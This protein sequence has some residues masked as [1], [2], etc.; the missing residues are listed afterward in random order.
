MWL[1]F[2]ENG[3]R[4]VHARGGAKLIGDL[5]RPDRDAYS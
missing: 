5:T 4:H 1:T 3:F 2:A